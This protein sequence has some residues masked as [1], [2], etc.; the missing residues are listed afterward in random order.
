MRG[1]LLVLCFA[2]VSVWTATIQTE[3]PKTKCEQERLN[4]M[5]RPLIGAFSPQCDEEG[6]Y[7]PKQCHGSTGHC[8]CVDSRGQERA[9]TRTPPGTPAKNCE[10]PEDP[11]TKCEQERLN[12]M[13]RPLIGAF[14]PQCDEEGHYRPKQCHGST[15]HCWCV[16]SRGQERA[17]TRTPPGTPA[18]NCEAPDPKTKCEQE[19]LN[20]MLRP[21]IGA[22]SP[23]CDEEGHYRPKQCHGSTGHCWC[24]DSRG[25]ER[26]GTRTP[27]GTPAKNCEAPGSG[28]MV[29]LKEGTVRGQYM[30]VLGSEKV[31]EQYLGIPFAQPPV[32]P[33]RLAAPLPAKPW[34][35]V[36]NTTEHPRMCLQNTDAMES[37]SEIMSMNVTLPAISEDCLYLN[38]YTP[39]Q[40]TG[41]EK[42]PVM[43]WVH[44][45]GLFM[46]GAAQYDGSVLAAYENIVVVVI[47]YRLGILGF[48]STGD[49]QA[50]GNWGFLDQIAALKWVQQNI[51]NFGGDAKSVTIA[52]ESAGGISTSMLTLSPLAKGLF[53]RTIF[54]S[55]AATLGTYSTKHPMVFAKAVANATDCDSSSTELL[56]ECLK[57]KTEE[58]IIKAT[59]KHK[60]LLGA[61][62]D[63]EFLTDVAEELLKKKEF[64]KVP[65]LLGV[66][67]HEFGWILPLN[68]A[69]KGWDKGMERQAVKTVMDQFFPKGMLADNDLI[70]DEYLKNAKTPED[71]RDGFTEMLGDFFM[72][73]PVIKVAGY[74]RDGDAHVYMYEFQHRPSIVKDIRPSFVKAD[75]GD[76]VGFMFGYCFWNG[77]IKVLGQFS[78]EE[79]ELCK[80]MMRYWGNFIR[81]GSPNGPGLV[82][83]PPY[84]QSNKYMN[85]GL[86]QTEEQGLK[87]D[88]IDFLQTGL[89]S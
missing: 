78:E 24:V 66:T 27:P 86:Q 53:Q 83:W 29:A 2:T 32:G 41:S 1:A 74:H 73:L 23:Q 13:L 37:L 61:T 85:L 70:I 87:Q 15:G 51:G 5:L 10:A 77:H 65:V 39:S 63:G 48:F 54:Q 25:Q 57:Q 40:P 79:N 72:V 45:G 76:E 26:A 60:I 22:F 59:E 33:L 3:D 31:V 38:V 14:S 88:R 6:H 82:N 67:N 52:G 64:L 58:D 19:R 35:G 71:I 36:K 16:D 43:L 11:K 28:P 42:L 50:Q 89:R 7:R 18:K 9:G 49:K 12:V 69:P 47:Q 30:R 81:T 80:T 34:E 21:L 75:H 84:D 4:V 46:G 68:F 56:V 55:G 8:W 62:V 20:V 44:G 17:G